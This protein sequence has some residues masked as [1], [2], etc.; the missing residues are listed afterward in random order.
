LR[1]A[2]RPEPH[3][4]PRPRPRPPPSPPRAGA[5][6]ADWR[7]CAVRWPAGSSWP[8]QAPA[9]RA[10]ARL[11]HHRTGTYVAQWLSASKR[12]NR[13]FQSELRYYTGSS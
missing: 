10:H 12:L 4:R 1:R 2:N 11:R 13:S 8:S 7:L 9:N 3:R 6:W 5:A